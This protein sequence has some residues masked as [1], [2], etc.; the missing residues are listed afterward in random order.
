MNTIIK[1]LKNKEAVNCVDY[2]K[3]SGQYN[4]NYSI[5]DNNKLIYDV[6][7]DICFRNIFTGTDKNL[8]SFSKNSKR[9]L[10][11]YFLED[12]TSLTESE[13]KT[14][15]RYLRQLQIPFTFKVIE[16]YDLNFDAVNFQNDRTVPVI[17]DVD[18][19]FKN[20]KINAGEG[21]DSIILPNNYGGAN[22]YSLKASNYINLNDG[23]KIRCF[24]KQ[25]AYVMIIDFNKVNFVKTKILSYFFRYIYEVSFDLIIKA[26]LKY[27]K[28]HPKEDFIRVFH[29][30]NSCF[31]NK[32]SEELLKYLNLP[33]DTKYFGTGGHTIGTSISN[34]NV[35]L[36]SV[37]KYIESCLE[38][39]LSAISKLFSSDRLSIMCKYQEDYWGLTKKYLTFYPN[40][41]ETIK[42]GIDRFLNS[43]PDEICKILG[44]KSIPKDYKIYL[45][46]E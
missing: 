9:K 41:D 4:T 46:N 43:K 33:K 10:I 22:K 32:S 29:L 7:R 14:Y 2:I 21:T 40:I 35:N 8:L 1:D 25:K 31:S 36:K 13:I 11:I 28:K 45:S 15:I 6:R 27:K 24:K 17:N 26:I 19:Y 30:F 23:N 39:D 38:N 3:T 37:L 34:I 16:D 5:I 12:Q 44:Y 42:Q 18:D 20:V